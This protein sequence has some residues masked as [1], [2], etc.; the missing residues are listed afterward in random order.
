MSALAS[1]ADRVLVESHHPLDNVIW[2]ALTTRHSELAFGGQTA[3][4]YDPAYTPFAGTADTSPQSL[5][6]LEG[7]TR[8][9]DEII[10]LSTAPIRLPSSFDR[11]DPGDVLQMTVAH[12]DAT[13]TRHTHLTL[14]ASDAGDMRQLVAETRPG[15]FSH[16]THEMGRFLGVRSDGRLVA[17]AGERVRLE[18]FTEISG[19]CSSATHRG[20]GLPAELVRAVARGILARGETPF[21]HVFAHNRAAVALYRKL[22]FEIRRKMCVA[23]LRRRAR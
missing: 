15:P 18:G 7:I 8:V 12:I 1:R 19:V 10:V 17:M 14:E 9:G 11:V 23:M 13:A 16:R 6:A 5:A 22:G 20:R 4:R 3:R 2:N 21:L